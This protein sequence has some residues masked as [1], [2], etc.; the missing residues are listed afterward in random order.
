MPHTCL[1]ASL[2]V[3]TDSKCYA[4]VFPHHHQVDPEELTLVY[5]LKKLMKNNW[6]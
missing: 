4:S 1:D 5:N 2:L 3:S 6:V